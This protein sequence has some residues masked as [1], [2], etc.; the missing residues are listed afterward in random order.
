[1][2][3]NIKIGI[4]TYYA[5]HNYGAALQAFALQYT[6]RKFGV[7]TEFLRYFDKHNE[8]PKGNGGS[9]LRVLLSNRTLLIELLF[10]P[11]RFLRVHKVSHKKNDAFNDFKKNYLKCSAEP[12]YDSEDLK[13]ANFLYDGFV[14]GSDMVWTPIGQNLSAYF[15]QFADKGKRFSYSPSMTGCS[16]YSAEDVTQIKNYLNSMDIIS[17]REQEGCDFVK[18]LIGH[19]VFHTLDP[20][21]LLSKEDW[22]KALNIKINKPAKPYIL[23]YNFKGLPKKAYKEVHRIAKERGWDILYVPMERSEVYSNLQHGLTNGCGPKEFVELFFNASFCVSNGY[24]GFLFSLISENPFIV[25]HREKENAWKSN[26]TRISD[27]MD[28]LG[29][30]NRYLDLDDDISDSLLEFNVTSI[31]R[32]LILEREK[33][34]MYLSNV[35]RCAADNTLSSPKEISNVRDLSIKKC[36]GCSLCANICPFNAIKMKENEEGFIVPDIDNEKCKECGKCAKL[37]PSVNPLKKQYP[38][39][40]FVCLSKDSL[41]ENS[42]SGGVFITLAKHYIEDLKGVVYGVV[43]DENFT[44]RH[45]EASTIEELIP[46]QNSKY[47]QSMMGTCY[48]QAK[49]RLD[50]GRYVLFSGTPCQIAGLKKFIGKDYEKLLTVEIICHGVPNQRFWKHY[51][52]E[53]GKLGDLHYYIFRNRANR[54]T[55]E[56]TQ[57]ATIGVNDD[58]IHVNYLNDPYYGPFVKCES[59]RKSCYYCQYACE[60]R[61][62][63]MTIG[64][65]DS[66]SN[67]PKFYPL[68]EKSSLLINTDKGM[69]IWNKVSERFD[70]ENLDYKVECTVNTPLNQPS[71]MPKN[72]HEIYNDLYSLDWPVFVKKYTEK[73]SLIK[74]SIKKVLKK[75]IDI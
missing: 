50:E 71:E 19:E 2:K 25:Y 45:K 66:Q 4:M 16:N 54:A 3:D 52:K 7:E 68:E 33:S 1:M 46:M 75:C 53:L 41:I 34:L 17:C 22:C 63:D 28:M 8:S 36:T 37:C 26:E 14:T 35:V 32:K 65:C 48:K 43:L 74:R 6:L 61:L 23:C 60:K 55:Q 69:C 24:H 5:V 11:S 31:N 70:Y 10:H 72:R 29:I 15:L 59:Y 9:K 40:S 20:T 18:E 21:I 57:E 73:N 51:L 58:K 39:V 64:D 42:A 38:K 27:F 30:R 47:I 49:G 56:A 13:T 12:Y 62:A 67:Y 44:C